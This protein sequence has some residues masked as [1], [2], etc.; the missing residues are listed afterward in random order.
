MYLRF[1][2][3]RPGRA[4]CSRRLTRPAG[5]FGGVDYARIL[6]I[7][8]DWLATEIEQ[9]LAWFAAHLERPRLP[10]SLEGERARQAHCWF[11]PEADEAIAEARHLARALEG[12]SQPI[13]AVKTRD[14][15]EIIWEDTQ[16]IVAVPTLRRARGHHPSQR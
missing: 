2:T 8:P 13:R 7:A 6:R 3:G 15:G 12:A 9:S 11:R 1:E 16:Q 14:P 4:R 5:L 10:L